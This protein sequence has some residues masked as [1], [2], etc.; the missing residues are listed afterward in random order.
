MDHWRS[1]QIANGNKL[2]GGG[3]GVICM[4]LVEA[5]PN[6]RIVLQDLTAQVQSARRK[7]EILAWVMSRC[8][9][10]WACRVQ[11]P[12]CP[13]RIPSQAWLRLYYVSTSRPCPND[14]LLVT[15]FSV[16]ETHLSCFWDGGLF[17]EDRYERKTW[18]MV[19]RASILG[20]TFPKPRN[21]MRRVQ[22]LLLSH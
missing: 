18:W 21:R 16:A 4:Q 13:C 19:S 2:I 6:L 22:L 11:S 7:D 20:N 17:A 14:F 12:G 10:D 8:D 5:H 15:I 9:W 1:H 3:I